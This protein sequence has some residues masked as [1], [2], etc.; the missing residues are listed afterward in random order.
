MSLQPKQPITLDFISWMM[1]VT[2][3]SIFLFT[4]TYLEAPIALQGM[5]AVIMLLA[6]ISLGFILNG[7]KTDPS[8]S[9][10]EMF[11][12]LLHTGLA[13][14]AVI[15]VN[16]VVQIYF[17]VEP[18]DQGLFSVLI[19]VSEECFFRLFL[20][21]WLVR[22]TN[23]FIGSITSS[24]VWAIYH[25]NRYGGQWEVFWIIWLSGI[26]L[27]FILISS[28]RA[29]PVLLAHGLVNWIAFG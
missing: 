13:I 14:G 16:S 7:F 4:A 21:T 1:I 12:M 10:S 6:G 29:G 26:V 23:V 20:C 11:S 27:S 18:M 24:A 5:F 25:L 22:V 3:L 28:K 15:L 8:I 9:S 2:A 17:A 19:G